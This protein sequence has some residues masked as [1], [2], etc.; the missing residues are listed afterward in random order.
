MAAAVAGVDFK[1]QCTNGQQSKM[2]LL[3]PWFDQYQAAN[4]SNRSF[5]AY[6]GTRP[7]EKD[8]CPPKYPS[9]R[10]DKIAFQIQDDLR[11]MSL[12]LLGPRND[13]HMKYVGSGPA[14]PPLIEGVVLDDV[15]I[16]FRCGDVLGGAKRYD[17]GM[18]R[19]NE[20][21]KWI[22]DATQSI[23]IL[24]QPFEASRNRKIDSRKT[25][26]CKK[27]V[28]ALVDYL[29]AFAKDAKISIHNSVN[30]TLPLAYARLTM[31]NYSITSLSSFGIFPIIG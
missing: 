18:I 23:G 6:G 12:T 14:M 28:Y 24:T 31:A 4:P 22:P 1:F 2:E 16:H 17:F 29:Q 10:I 25:D 19:F 15:A 9:L 21:K 20:Y 11:R 26:N 27:V 8:A 13:D 30:E 5:W 3:L 7:N